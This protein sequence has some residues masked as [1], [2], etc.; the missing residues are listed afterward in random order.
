MTDRQ[1]RPKPW[2]AVVRVLYALAAALG[3]AA[4]LITALNAWDRI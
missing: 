2:P 1:Q 4:T 3:S